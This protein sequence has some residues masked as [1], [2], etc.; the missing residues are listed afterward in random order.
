M[1][2]LHVRFCSVSVRET[3]LWL[4]CSV[5]LGQNSKTLLR[6]VTTAQKYIFVTKLEFDIFH[7]VLYRVCQ[8]ITKS[9]Q[10]RICK[11]K[12]KG[13]LRDDGHILKMIFQLSQ[14]MC[15]LYKILISTRFILS[16]ANNVYL[17][18]II[19]VMI[20]LTLQCTNKGSQGRWNV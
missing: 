3:E 20:A 14:P 11:R 10:L 16:Y 19:L 13:D 12:Y 15:Q 17:G 8:K 2:F 7:S 6:L 5:R 9:I 1:R 4:I 18:D